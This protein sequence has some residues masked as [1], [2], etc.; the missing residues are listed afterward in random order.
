MGSLSYLLWRKAE[1]CWTA[2]LWAWS[3]I[4]RSS[5]KYQF[6]RDKTCLLSQQ[7]YACCGKTFV[8]IK[9]CLSH[10]FAATCF[11][12]TKVSLLWQKYVMGTRICNWFRYSCAKMQFLIAYTL[13]MHSLMKQLS[14]VKHTYPR[15]NLIHIYLV[16]TKKPGQQTL[17]KFDENTCG[18]QTNAI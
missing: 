5:H 10:T 14:L 2:R 9:L 17:V 3:V 18:Q 12:V 8:T 16:Q 13:H 6:C 1:G 15:I 11:V 4:G 7:K